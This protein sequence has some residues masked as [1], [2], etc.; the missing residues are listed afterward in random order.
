MTKDLRRPLCNVFYRNDRASEVD[1]LFI[2]PEYRKYGCLRTQGLGLPGRSCRFLCG[3][4]SAIRPTAS[5]SGN[6]TYQD[7]TQR[8]V[9][10]EGICKGCR[11][12]GRQCVQGSE[13]QKNAASGGL[14]H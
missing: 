2:Q 5:I 9:S 14:S 1:G 13:Y 6:A 12:L 11:E 3:T 8:F 10:R 4:A 7:L